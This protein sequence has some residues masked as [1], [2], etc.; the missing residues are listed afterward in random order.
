MRNSALMRPGRGVITITRC[1]RYTDSNT[2]WVTKMTVL[3]KLRHSDSRSLLSRKRVISSSAANGSSI[4]RISG[5]VTNAR[6]SETR[7]F[8]PPD[9]SRG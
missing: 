6:A 7:I 2:E 3:R 1:D 5:S 8:M 4:S 9:N